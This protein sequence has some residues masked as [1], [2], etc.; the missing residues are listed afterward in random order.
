MSTRQYT[1][2]QHRWAP[3][4]TKPCDLWGL[5]CT[6]SVSALTAQSRPGR[7]TGC[8]VCRRAECR[9]SRSAR[10][11]PC[12]RRECPRCRSSPATT[13]TRGRGRQ[14]IKDAE[15]TFLPFPWADWDRSELS[16]DHE[17]S[18]LFCCCITHTP[19]SHA[20]THLVLDVR[21][22]VPREQDAADAAVVQVR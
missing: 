15:L 4:I 21:R 9:A 3:G 20:S 14:C 2:W 5:S 13:H 10:W 11:R 22:G 1:R 12:P 19:T 8:G 6:S 7:W 16:L 17:P 18:R